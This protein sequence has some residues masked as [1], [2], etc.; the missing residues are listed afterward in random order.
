MFFGPLS[1]VSAVINTEPEG[2]PCIP[3]RKIP[4]D[5]EDSDIG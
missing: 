1:R 3:L 5:T 4:K 2:K